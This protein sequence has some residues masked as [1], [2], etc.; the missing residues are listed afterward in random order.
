[1]KVK[2]RD[3]EDLHFR[4]AKLEVELQQAQKNDLIEVKSGEILTCVVV[5]MILAH[6]KV[7]VKHGYG[8]L[9]PD[10]EVDE[11]SRQA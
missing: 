7:H 1:M 6:L 5:P 11:T 8:W 9:L 10:G 3:W 2:R 4:L